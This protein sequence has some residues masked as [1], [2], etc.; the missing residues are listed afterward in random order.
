MMD[1]ERWLRVDGWVV[2]VVVVIEW[3]LHRT[4]REEMVVGED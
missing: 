1:D 4:V 2:V 3:W